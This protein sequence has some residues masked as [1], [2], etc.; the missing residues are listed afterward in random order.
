MWRRRRRLMTTTTR[1]TTRLGRRLDMGFSDIFERYP[2]LRMTIY[3][4]SGFDFM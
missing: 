4:P 1:M 2:L 3:G